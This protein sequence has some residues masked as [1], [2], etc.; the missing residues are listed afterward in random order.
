MWARNWRKVQEGAAVLTLALDNGGDDIPAEIDQA[1]FDLK[2]GFKT[3]MA[4][5]LALHHFWP[6]LFKFIKLVNG[7]AADGKLS[8][9]S[10]K[11]CLDEMKAVDTILG[12]LDLTQMPIPLSDLPDDV[13]GM[14]AD[15]QKARE[16]RDFVASDEL[17][18]AMREAGYRLEDTASIP[19]VFKK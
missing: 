10:A 6:A 14:L 7:W 3:A 18:D 16:S 19:R 2:A 4:E 11:V 12:I 1:V 15:R 9:A 17:R 8:G 5:D 13:Q